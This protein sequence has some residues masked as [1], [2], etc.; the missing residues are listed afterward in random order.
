MLRG[1]EGG[2]GG[3]DPPPNGQGSR[4]GVGRGRGG[5]EQGRG[6]SGTIGGWSASSAVPAQAAQS[7]R[8]STA[9]GMSG[10]VFT[11]FAC[12][13]IEVMKTIHADVIWE[14]HRF[15]FGKKLQKTPN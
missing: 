7:F 2:E 3:N 6:W 11:N 9:R 14:Q 1:E 10:R 4:A 15:W 12:S 13:E 8:A 5:Q